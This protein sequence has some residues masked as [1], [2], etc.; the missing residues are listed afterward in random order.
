MTTALEDF[1]FSLETTWLEE[2]ESEF[3]R[4]V[5]LKFLVPKHS[6]PAEVRSRIISTLAHDLGVVYEQDYSLEIS[7]PYQMPWIVEVDHMCTLRFKEEE[8]FAM[9][10]LHYASN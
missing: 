5:V 6:N 2:S 7:L 10:K 4:V 3:P 9:L 1:N 8:H